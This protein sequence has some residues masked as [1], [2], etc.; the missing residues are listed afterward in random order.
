MCSLGQGTSWAGR[1]G[2]CISVG[3]AQRAAAVGVSAVCLLLCCAHRLDAGRFRRRRAGVQRPYTFSHS[4]SRAQD[5][6]RQAMKA[7][8]VLLHVLPPHNREQYEKSVIGPLN[9]FGNNDGVLRTK[10]PPP[11]HGK[12][13][14]KT[15]SLTG[16]SSP[17]EDVSA[18]LQQ[19]RGP[20]VPRIGRKPSSPSL[21]PL[22][23]FGGKK[24]AKKIK[25]DLKKGNY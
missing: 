12:S 9:I 5:V 18:A 11:V 7:P 1:S 25:I 21:S 14:I 19:S 3:R 6:F 17:E 20:R 23:G 8:C 16:A 2:N 4:R 10:P 24:N 22:M 13:G 15:V